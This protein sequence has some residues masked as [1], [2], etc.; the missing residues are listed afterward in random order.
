MASKS[1][2]GSLLK[3][4]L[5][6]IIV[7]LAFYYIFKQISGNWEAVRASFRFTPSSLGGALLLG[8]QPLL[9]PFGWWLALRKLGS[10]AGWRRAYWVWSASNLGKYAPGKVW[11]VLGRFYF[12]SGESKALVAESIAIEVVANLWAASLAAA[13]STLFRS[14]PWAPA[15]WAAAA[16]GLAFAL[17]PR[18]IQLALRLPARLLKREFK[19]PEAFPRLAFLGLSAYYYALWLLLGLGIWLLGT[20]F[21]TGADPLVLGGSY[22]LA[23]M[24]GYLF[25]LVPGGFGVR[26]G[27][28]TAMA[29]VNPGVAGVLAVAVRLGITIWEVLAFGIA[30]LLRER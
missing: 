29:G 17:Y 11:N 10:T 22:A 5:A 21:G 1:R 12:L 14:S 20:S 27:L 13:T 3:N 25:L 24:G 2:L 30:L 26:E 23:W 16:G 19:A 6:G 9:A 18:S 15:A 8:V 28:F 4:A 7:L